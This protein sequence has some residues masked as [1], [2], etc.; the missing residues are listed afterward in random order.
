VVEPSRQLFRARRWL[1][2]PAPHQV[3][4]FIGQHPATALACFAS[5]LAA[6]TDTRRRS[7]KNHMHWIDPAQLPLIEGA[8][9]RFTVNSQGEVDGLL[10]DMGIGLIQLVHFP[11]HMADE[12]VAALKPG[13]TV[14]VRGLKP[15]D[16][17]VVA[18]IALECVDGTEIVDRGPPKHADTRGGPFR[19][20]PVSASGKIRLTL[21]TAKG[22][23]RGALLE[24]GTI[25][26]MPLKQAEQIRQRLRPG[27]TI[28]I[29]G[30]G[31]ETPHGRVVEVHHVATPTGKF[32]VTTKSN[33]SLPAGPRA[34]HLSP[35]RD[36]DA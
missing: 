21:F 25:L 32:G 30:T 6:N 4:K 16:A 15:R 35:D 11:S 31:Y 27:E 23:A 29:H 34:S 33:K 7:E 22:K 2:S 10:L 26:R 20:S 9:E 13:D 18:A 3:L 8:I 5:A 36:S 24:D 12:V 28:D 19:P 17:D 14:R 1:L